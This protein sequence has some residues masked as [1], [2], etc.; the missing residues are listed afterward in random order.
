M[1]NPGVETIYAWGSGKNLALGGDLKDAN[2][3]AV[4]PFNTRVLLNQLENATPL[5][6]LISGYNAADTSLNPFSPQRRRPTIGTQP[7]ANFLERLSG[8]A[9]LGIKPYAPQL[10]AWSSGNRLNNS[11]KAQIKNEYKH[12][13][14]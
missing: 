11:I 8:Y 2:N 9:G 7:Q 5:G 1:F 13:S 3:N 10:N 12:R 14:K 4:G 6:P